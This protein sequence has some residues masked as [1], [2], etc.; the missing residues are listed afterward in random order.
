MMWRWANRDTKTGFCGLAGN[1]LT[2]FLP[3]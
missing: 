2:N 1:P 3:E